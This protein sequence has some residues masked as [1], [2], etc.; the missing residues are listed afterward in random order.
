MEKYKYTKASRDR[1]AGSA[2][3][4]AKDRLMNGEFPNVRDHFTILAI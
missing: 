4:H 2:I 3:Y 1:I